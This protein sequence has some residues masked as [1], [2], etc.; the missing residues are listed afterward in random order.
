[1]RVTLDEALSSEVIRA[2]HEGKADIGILWDETDTGSLET[3]PYRSDT[4][5]VVVKANHPLAK[6]K[7]LTFL[8]TLEHVSVGVAPNGT[9]DLMLKRYAA[10]EGRSLNHR[11][12]VASLDAGCRIVAAG[13][14]I[15]I[16]PREALQLHASYGSL[17]LIELTE[18]W[19][20]RQFLIAHKKQTPD[21]KLN[22][23]VLRLIRALTIA[24]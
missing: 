14:G 3:T 13:L 22:E 18:P 24:R 4:L 6:R 1:V 7:R 16:L 20:R 17:K 15:A 5:C 2:L 23:D 19:A 8:E 11:I 21:A 10:K 9:M 12:Q